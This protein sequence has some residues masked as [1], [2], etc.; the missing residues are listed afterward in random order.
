MT[1]RSEVREVILDAWREKSEERASLRVWRRVEAIAPERGLVREP[2]WV[3]GLA[4]AAVVAE[5][6]ATWGVVVEGR[7][8]NFGVA[9]GCSQ[10]VEVEGTAWFCRFGRRGSCR[11]GCC[12]MVMPGDERQMPGEGWRDLRAN[13]GS[14][15][16]S[17]E[18]S[19][20]DSSSGER[21][22]GSVLAV[23]KCSVG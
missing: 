20:G 18:Q 15:S 4:R 22:F 9:T 8:I 2:L 16:S 11:I 19:T 5:W 6:W 23:L 14:G 3:E 10:A 21:V 7:R 13:Y 17:R 1:A 12:T